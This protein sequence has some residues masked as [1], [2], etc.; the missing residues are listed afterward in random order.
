M[1]L[2]ALK[3]YKFPRNKIGQLAKAGVIT[4][5]KKGI[6]VKS[7]EPFHNFVLANMICGPSY[8]SEDSALSH[9]GLIPEAVRI[10]TSTTC[11]HKRSFST[12]VGEFRYE[13]LPMQLYPIGIRRIAESETHAFLIAAPEKALFDRLRR[14]PGIQSE[15][16]LENYLFESMRLDEDAVA[17]FRLAIFQQLR[18]QSGRVFANLLYDLVKKMRR[19]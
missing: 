13:S 17:T 4:R 10:T 2:S 19:L 6:Y 9:Y 3:D 15:A 12:P 8:V 14:V 11:G 1:L 16:N 18:K 7:G 5:V